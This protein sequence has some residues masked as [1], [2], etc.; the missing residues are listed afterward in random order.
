[1]HVLHFHLDFS[2]HNL[3]NVSDIYDKRFRQGLSGPCHEAE[4]TP[5]CVDDQ[6]TGRSLLGI[7]QKSFEQ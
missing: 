1:M 6:D 5:W 4:T 2:Q 3:G 7:D